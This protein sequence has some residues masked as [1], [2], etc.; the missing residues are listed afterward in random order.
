VQV[1]ATG[2]ITLDTIADYARAGVD[3]VSTGMLTHSVRSADLGLAV[4][5]GP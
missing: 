4:R 3:F 1:E 2:G 5:G